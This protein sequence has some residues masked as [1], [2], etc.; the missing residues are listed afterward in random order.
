[1]VFESVSQKRQP[2]ETYPELL[3]KTVLNFYYKKVA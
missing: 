2:H 1:M 3:E